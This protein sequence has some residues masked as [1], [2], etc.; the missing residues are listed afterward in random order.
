MSNKNEI[1]YKL[2][3]FGTSRPRRNANSAIE[4]HPEPLGPQLPRIARLMA[5]A[6][7][8]DGMWQANDG[9]SYAELARLGHVSRARLTQIMNLL[10]LAPDIQERL[11][12]L[13]PVVKGRDELNE[14]ALRKLSRYYDWAEQRQALER[15]LSSRRPN[16]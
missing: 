6:I 2:S 1:R 10:Q 4:S 8:L 16:R 13:P 9:L 15:I 11:L 3:R 12:F 5:L 14:S 7:K